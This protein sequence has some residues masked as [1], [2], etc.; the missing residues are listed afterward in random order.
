VLESTRNI[1][2]RKRWEHRQHLLLGELTHRVN[3]TLAVAQSIAHQTMRGSRSIED[4]GERFEARLLAL[5]RAHS[6]LIGAE[7]KGG[8][9]GTLVRNELAPYASDNPKRFTIE[10]EA[11]S[12]PPDLVTSFGLV[13]HE[14][15]TNAAKHGALSRVS[16]TLNVSWQINHRNNQRLLTIIWKEQGGP[17]AEPPTAR[18]FGSSL[19]EK[20]IPNSTVKREFRAEG[21]GLRDRAA[22]ARDV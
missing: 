11:V 21:Y 2:E 4:F 7:W 14:L 16:G 19:I 8:D 9:L 5:A 20:G 6:V 17:T 13:L 22:A 10:G 18:G 1:T 15:A 3:N 12:L